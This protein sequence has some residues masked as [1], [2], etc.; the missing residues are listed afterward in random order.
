MRDGLDHPPRGSGRQL[1]IRIE[2]DHV[3]D[4][5]REAA[6]DQDLLESIACQKGIQLPDLAALALPPDPLL[7]ALRPDA[8][9]MEQHKA[10]SRV[11]RVQTLDAI[12]Y[13]FEQLGVI[14]SGRA[15][16]IG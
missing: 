3:T 13:G 1:R 6:F 8:R 7:L 10:A 16:E 15:G 2:R 11:A 5:K 14:G 4:R 12:A 9:P